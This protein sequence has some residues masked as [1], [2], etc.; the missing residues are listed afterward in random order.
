MDDDT[1]GL[2]QL[3]QAFREHK[4]DTCLLVTFAESL[5][6][7]LSKRVAELKQR[8]KVEVLYGENLYGRLLELLADPDVDP[9]QTN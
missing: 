4:V 6:P 7:S 5:G 2:D 8:Y 9:T 1:R 3:E